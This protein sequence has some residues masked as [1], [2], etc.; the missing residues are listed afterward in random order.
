MAFEKGHK[1]V[2]GRIQG[3]KNKANHD[4]QRVAEEMGIDPIQILL[5]IAEGDWKA[6]G[7]DSDKIKVGMVEEERIPLS[8][9]KAAAKDVAP[10]LKPALKSIDIEANI[11]ATVETPSIEKYLEGLIEDKDESDPE[12]DQR[13]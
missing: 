8:L 12:Q 7:Y 5:W 13:P 10:Y 9:R 2:G 1:K 3:T 6:L 11:N 4:A